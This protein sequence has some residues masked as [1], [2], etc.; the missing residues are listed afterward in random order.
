VR[1]NLQH[2]S[3]WLLSQP[4]PRFRSTPS[5]SA[6]ICDVSRPTYEPLYGKKLPTI[7]RKDFFMNILYTESFLPQ[8]MYN[9]MLLFD[10]TIL[11][12]SG[13]FDYWNQPLNVRMR[14]CYLHWHEAGLCCYLVIHI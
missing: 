14:A 12:H 11:K 2:R 9:R 3:F 7:N 6:K 4:L 13:H 10:S 1:R 5:S 8:E